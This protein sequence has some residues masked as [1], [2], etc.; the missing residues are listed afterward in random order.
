MFDY[1]DDLDKVDEFVE[2][3]KKY[4]TVTHPKQKES[5]PIEVVKHKTPNGYAVIVS[6]GFDTR[7]LLA[8]WKDV[9]LKRDDLLCI[10]WSKKG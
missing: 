2:D 10:E 3:V 7:E 8:K 5:V 9:G 4:S 1:D 6:H